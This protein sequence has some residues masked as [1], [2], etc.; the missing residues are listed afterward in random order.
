MNDLSLKLIVHQL[1][2]HYQNLPPSSQLVSLSLGLLEEFVDH[3]LRHAP[4]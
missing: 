2:P 1:V 4:P 3:Q